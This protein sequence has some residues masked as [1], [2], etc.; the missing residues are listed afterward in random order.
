MK[1]SLL[2]LDLSQGEKETVF[3]YFLLRLLNGKDLWKTNNKE[4]FVYIAGLLLNLIHPTHQRE[5]Q[6]YLVAYEADL[7]KYLDEAKD[8]AERYYCLKFNA[9]HLLVS[10]G[11]FHARQDEIYFANQ[12][13]GKIYYRMAAS[14][15]HQIYRKQ[16]I[17]MDI[18]EHLSDYFGD[19]QNHLLKLRRSYLQFVNKLTEI[20]K[21]ELLSQVHR[22]VVS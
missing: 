13:R 15:A 18:M 21:K 20:E 2:Y 19:Y 22:L 11:L 14:C 7:A 12:D 10:G 9:D 17:L 5:S 6:K 1:T 4:V 8:A 3:G 16:T